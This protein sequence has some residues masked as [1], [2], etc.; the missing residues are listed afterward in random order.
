M[1]FERA[2]RPLSRGEELKARQA[3]FAARVERAS[4]W[5]A[6]HLPDLTVPDGRPCSYAVGAAMGV[7][8]MQPELKGAAFVAEVRTYRAWL[9][10]NVPVEDGQTEAEAA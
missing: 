6:V 10:R 2:H 5:C 9:M 3:E 4:G 7:R 1:A 8:R